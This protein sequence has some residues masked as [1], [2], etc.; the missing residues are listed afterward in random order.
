MY[1]DETQWFSQTLMTYKDSQ[2]ATDGYLRL[3]ISTNTKDFLSFN[4]TNLGLSISNGMTKVCNLNIQNA[5]DLLLTLKGI[6]SNPN[7]VYENNGGQQILKRYNNSQDLVFE[8]L[9]ETNNNERVVRIT[10]RNS[11]TDFAKIVIPYFTFFVI[12]TRLKEYV[13]R[14]E[15]ICLSLPN[16]FLLRELLNSNRN[17]GPAIKSLPT[18][19]V[20]QEISAPEKEVDKKEIQQTQTTIDDLD[21]FIGGSDMGNVNLP[22]LQSEKI[23]KTESRI[24][25]HAVKSR[26]IED[27]LHNDIQ[28]LNDLLKVA[29]TNLAPISFLKER[30]GSKLGSNSSYE[31]LSGINDISYKSLIYLSKVISNTTIMNYTENGV[32]IPSSLP[33][34]K[35]KTTKYNDDNLDFAFDLLMIGSYL[36][37]FRR[38]AEEKITD[39][40][41]NGAITYLLFRCYTDAMCF[42][43]LEGK[44][45]PVILSAVTTRFKQYDNNGFFDKFKK[46]LEDSNCIQNT[47]D[48]IAFNAEDFCKKVINSSPFIEEFHNTLYSNNSVKLPTNNNYKLE[49]I[50]NEV[51]PLEVYEKLGK[52]IKDKDLSSI[53]E[54]VLSLFEGK[55]KQAKP[56][57]EKKEPET[58]LQRLIR[59]YRDEIPEKYR[60]KFNKEISELGDSK[61]YDFESEKF[62]LEEFGEKIIKVL[63]N[64]DPENDPKVTKNYKYFYG[65]F[66]NEIMTKDSI[67]LASKKKE[68]E[69]PEEKNW[70]SVFDDIEF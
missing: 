29:E 43:F 31:V 56:K 11:E 13:N 3:S 66:E 39:S 20:E 49:Q 9:H 67:L 70:G 24:E 2:Y 41:K 57:K 61:K 47:V 40:Y 68:G 60:E 22:D 5:T 12:S 10:I 6:I 44:E 21:K 17:I 69:E 45:N 4:P 58:N 16:N 54:D 52:S 32:P 63:Y 35:F 30:F 7:S 28:N 55:K 34:L 38:K 64:W 25:G 53:S 15:N 50:I 18:K 37:A 36:R 62:P 46:V 42:S 48:D 8:F 14:Y 65:K 23:T 33:V 1:E 19:F 51:V 59:S 26:F 27:V